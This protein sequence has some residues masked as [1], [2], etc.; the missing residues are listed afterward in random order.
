MIESSRRGFITG[1][2][3][4]VTAP[5]IVRATNIMPVK[6]VRYLS[7]EEIVNVALRRLSEEN[8]FLEAMNDKFLMDL[9][10]FGTAIMEFP[11]HPNYFRPVHRPLNDFLL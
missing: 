4:L 9:A 2:I 10:A 5:A 3:S 11:G 1:L 6:A 8:R 7:N